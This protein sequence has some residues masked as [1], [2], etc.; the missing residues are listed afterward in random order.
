VVTR[1]S[2]RFDVRLGGTLILISAAVMAV[3]SYWYPWYLCTH[4]SSPD[5]RYGIAMVAAFP[6]WFIGPAIAGRALFRIFAAFLRGKRT[7]ADYGVCIC[8]GFLALAG[9]SPLLMFTWN[10]LL[11]QGAVK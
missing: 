5:D 7:A 9:F 8:A 2:Y 1:L 3:I 6:F 4:H 11:P 10:T